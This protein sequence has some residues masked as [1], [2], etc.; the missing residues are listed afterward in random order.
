MPQVKG[1]FEEARKSEHAGVG[2]VISEHVVLKLHSN[3]S[4]AAVRG[5]RHRSE[6]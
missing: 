1:K 2:G 6:R 4:L 3:V 5:G